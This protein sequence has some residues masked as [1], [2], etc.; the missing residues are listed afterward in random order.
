MIGLLETVLLIS[1]I[2]SAGQARSLAKADSRILQQPTNQARSQRPSGSGKEAH[3]E[4]DA[5]KIEG[6]R[7]GHVDLLWAS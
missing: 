2:A 5:D 4:P 6:D 3:T 7:R 1:T